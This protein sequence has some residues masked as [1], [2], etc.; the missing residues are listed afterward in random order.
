MAECKCHLYLTEWCGFFLLFG[1]VFL[2]CGF[3]CFVLWCF[4]GL[5]FF[6]GFGFVGFVFVLAVVFFFSFLGTRGEQKNLNLK[7][8]Q[9]SDFFFLHNSIDVWMLSHTYLE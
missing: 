8:E 2:L 6:W 1:W 4:G 9:F 3:F 7:H 5:G